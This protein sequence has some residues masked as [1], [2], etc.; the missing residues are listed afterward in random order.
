VVPRARWRHALRCGEDGLELP[1][2]GL[3]QVLEVTDCHKG[4]GGSAKPY[5][6]MRWSLCQNAMRREPKS[7][8]MGPKVAKQHVPRTT[9]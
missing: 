8:R 3:E 6:L 7:Q 5:Q 4:V 9:S 2:D 1:E